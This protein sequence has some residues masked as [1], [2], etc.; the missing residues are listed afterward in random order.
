MKWWVFHEEQLEA[1][2]AAWRTAEAER[3]HDIKA[4]YDAQRIRDFL[5]S[6][7]AAPLFGGDN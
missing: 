4:E 5:A 7:E 1:A 6:P 2:L 3:A